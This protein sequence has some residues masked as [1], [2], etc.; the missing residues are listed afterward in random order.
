MSKIE[1]TSGDYSIRNFELAD[2]NE[3]YL[4]WLNDKTHLR[5]SSQRLAIHTV[6]SSIKYLETF[7]STSNHFM[8]IVFKKIPIGTCTLY[9]SDDGKSV[10]IGILIAPLHSGNGHGLRV[11]KILLNMIKKMSS[12][13]QVTAGTHNQNLAMLRIFEQSGMKEKI[14]NSL[15]SKEYRYF[16]LGI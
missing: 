13:C 8:L 15:E 1:H 14:G 11:W 7:K 12:V 16:T 3:N 9:F 4:S 5:Y 10:D 6:D 2:I